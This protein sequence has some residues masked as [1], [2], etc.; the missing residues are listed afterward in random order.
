MRIIFAG[1]PD[2]AATSLAALLASGHQVVAVL[3]QPDRPAGRG[4]KPVASEVK[5]LAEQHRLPVLQPEK[6]KDPAV[7]AQLRAFE[8]DVMVVVAYGLIIPQAVLAIPRHGCLN[9]HGSL[10][11]RWRGAAPVHRAIAAG[12][13]ESGV[14]IMQMDV[15]LDTGPMLHKVR[16]PITPEDTGGSL[17]QRI[18]TLGAEALVTVLD[19][20]PAALARAEAQPEEGVTYAHKL[21]KDEG[22]LDWS[23]DARALHDQVRAFNPWPVAW[24]TLAGDTLR[25]WASEA[26]HDQRREPPGTVVAVSP[27]GVDVACG[28]GVLRLVTLQLPGKKAMPV[29]DLLRGR[30]DAL[31]TGQTLGGAA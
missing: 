16:T 31:H 15:G 28:Q 5:Q 22:R 3:T 13:T 24:T 7:Q 9:V 2:F 1:T 4:R 21:T 25:V 29:A 10:L 27:A 19:D 30:P 6:L 20:L 23:R 26:I 14:T 18:A 17:Y 12:D 8:A 11:P